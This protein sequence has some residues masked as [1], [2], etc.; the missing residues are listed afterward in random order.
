MFIV[1]GPPGA[2]KSSVLSLNRFAD[3]VFNADDRAAELNAGSYQ[4]IPLSVRATVNREFEE[5]VHANI[6]SGTSFA[7]E[8]TLRS[9]ITF[10]QAKLAPRKQLPGCD[11]VRRS[12]N[13]GT[14]Y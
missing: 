11:A 8:T 1:A 10:D 13:A 4:D 6:R 14:S 5:F 12:G 9:S 3:R 7:L 2:G